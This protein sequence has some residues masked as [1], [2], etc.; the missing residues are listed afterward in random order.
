MFYLTVFLGN[1]LRKLRKVYKVKDAEAII[2][3]E[4]RKKIRDPG[5]RNF[6]MGGMLKKPDEDG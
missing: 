3:E 2:K 5:D 4:A 6:F 1:L